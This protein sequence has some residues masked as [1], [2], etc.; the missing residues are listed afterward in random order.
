MLMNT[1]NPA[2][3]EQTSARALDG[4]RVLDLSRVLAGPMTAMVLA[5]LGAEVI[6]VESPHGDD[7]RHFGPFVDGESGYYRMLNRGKRGIVLNFKDETDHATLLDLVHRSDV[8][9]ENFRP[10]VMARLG[11]APSELLKINPRLVVVSIS[12]FGQEGSMSGIPAFDVVAQAMSGLMAITGWPEGKPT[13]I[14]SSMGD[15]IPGLYGAIAALGALHERE[16]SGRGQ[17]IDLSMLDSLIASL[18]SVGIRALYGENPTRIGNDHGLSVPFSTYD[19]SNGPVVV[20]VTNDKLFALL[21]AAL[22]REDWLEDPRFANQ[23]A[24]NNHREEMRA[25]LN[26]ALSKYTV[27]EAVE[28][29]RSHGVPTSKVFTAEEAVTSD[30]VKERGTVAV[31]S[32]GFKTFAS[33]IRMRGSVPPVPAPKLGEHEGD[34]ARILAE[35]ERTDAATP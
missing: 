7:S 14:G 30:Y 26:G 18:E 13:R 27:D 25:E 23:E 6:K 21:V 31:E 3:G 2:A 24:R 4:I 29:L 10:G 17:H 22:G 9:V 35:P 34:I 8:L 5:D 11:L 20:A 16:R 19:A 1:T 28:L 15:I 33:P 12:G 32:D